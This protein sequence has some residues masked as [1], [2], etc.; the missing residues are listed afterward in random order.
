MKD[1]DPIHG[2]RLKD[3]V[4]NAPGN[5]AGEGGRG[6]RGY[7]LCEERFPLL[8]LHFVSCIIPVK[9]ETEQF[10]DNTGGDV[11]EGMY[12]RFDSRVGLVLTW[13]SWQFW[14]LCLVSPTSTAPSFGPLDCRQLWIVWKGEGYE[15]ERKR[16]GDQDVNVTVAACPSS[17]S[18]FSAFC[19]FPLSLSN[20][21][22]LRQRQLFVSSTTRT[23]D[24]QWFIQQ[25]TT[26]KLTSSRVRLGLSE[27]ERKA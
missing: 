4:Q 19:F 15:R 18:S 2:R 26:R 22:V 1:D 5:G 7:I 11:F 13:E 6:E 14:N 23:S 24:P 10:S 17:C 8:L 3:E 25:S 27:T 12:R 16:R 9:K 20:D 21:C